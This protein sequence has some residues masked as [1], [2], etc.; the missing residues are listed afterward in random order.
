M[1]RSNKRL[2][3]MDY[4]WRPQP[5]RQRVP[6]TVPLSDPHLETPS[7]A[8]DVLLTDGKFRVRPCRPSDAEAIYAAVRESIAELSLWM[9]WCPSDFSIL[10]FRPWIE[11]RANAW[12]DGNEFD[13]AVFDERDAS[14]LGVCGFNNINRTH[15]FGNLG[16]WVRT[17]RTGQGVA[18]AATWLVAEFGFTQLGFTRLEIVAAV[19]NIAS[20]RVAEKVRATREGVERNRYVVH[21]RIHDAIMYSLIPDDLKS[22]VAT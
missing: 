14:L 18:T 10:H 21:G 8:N 9:P 20:Q 5:N 15:N 22:Q 13:F 11:S 7:M 19:D 2:R 3:L 12:A 17:S 16:Y 4:L 6:P 1:R